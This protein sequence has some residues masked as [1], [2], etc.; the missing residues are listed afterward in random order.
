MLPAES[1][2]TYVG[3][4]AV[5]VELAGLRLLTDPLLG[6]GILH[7]RRQVE[8]PSIENLRALDAI[9]ISH[10]HHDHLDLRS[11]RRL[12]PDCP[13]IVPRG[14]ASAVRRGGASD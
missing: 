6:S 14:C 11:L 13:L 10:A 5:L 1:G 12:A 7:V 8:A 4:G 9:L 3:H 2:L